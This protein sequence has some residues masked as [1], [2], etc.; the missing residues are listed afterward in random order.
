MSW[1][2]RGLQLLPE[3]QVP[4]QRENKKELVILLSTF[5]K[6]PMA[7]PNEIPSDKSQD[8]TIHR[9]LT[10]GHRTEQRRHMRRGKCKTQVH[11]DKLTFFPLLTP[12]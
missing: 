3:R 9:K 10:L 11:V 7:E 12:S 1:R 5:P 4:K 6:S 8:D 2:Q